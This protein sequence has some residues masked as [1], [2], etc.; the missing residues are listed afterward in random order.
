MGSQEKLIVISDRMRNK[1]LRCSSNYYTNHIS[2]TK[3]DN[4]T[5]INSI[6][7]KQEKLCSNSTK[8]CVTPG[9]EAP[10]NVF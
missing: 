3:Q 2:K 10:M 4:K 6:S 7:F 8:K 5:K 9:L 1:K